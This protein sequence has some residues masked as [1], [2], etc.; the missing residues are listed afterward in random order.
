MQFRA[1]GFKK[2]VVNMCE[3]ANILCL[4]PCD[5][6]VLLCSVCLCQLPRMMSVNSQRER[7][8]LFGMQYVLLSFWSREE[9]S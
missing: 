1:L 5:V 8:E 4:C 3:N 2:W 9:S 7:Q 6:I